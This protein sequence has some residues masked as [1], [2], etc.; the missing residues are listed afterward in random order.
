MDLPMFCH[1]D[2]EEPSLSCLTERQTK[3]SDHSD[4]AG[5]PYQGESGETVPLQVT[6]VTL[7]G[8]EGKSEL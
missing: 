8:C 5:S 2:G 6:L 4:W 1:Q 3:R 7:S